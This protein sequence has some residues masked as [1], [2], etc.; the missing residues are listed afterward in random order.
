[1]LRGVQIIGIVIC[2]TLLVS[3][4]IYFRKERRR[5]GTFLIWIAVW[6]SGIIVFAFPDIG[7][8]FIGFMTLQS[9]VVAFIIIGLLG[10]YILLF[11]TYRNQLEMEKKL[12]ELIHSFALNEYYKRRDRENE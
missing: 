10:A 4:I 12:N 7:Y 8:L 11:R 5:I 6:T 9:N 3:A 1:M 2:A